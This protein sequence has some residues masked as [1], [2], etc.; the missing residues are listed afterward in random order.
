MN[1]N[2]DPRK[3]LKQYAALEEA[4]KSEIIQILSENPKGRY[5]YFDCR[6]DDENEAYCASQFPV[7]EGNEEVIKICGVGL[8]DDNHIVIITEDDEEKWF[9]PDEFT[10]A[11]LDMY[12]FVVDNLDYAKSSDCCDSE[13]PFDVNSVEFHDGLAAIE[14]EDGKWGYIDKTGQVVIPCQ[15]EETEYFSDGFA[16]V[17]DKDDKWGFIDKTGQVVIPCQWENVSEFEEGQAIVQ[18]SNEMF[19]IIDKNGKMVCPCKWNY[20][21]NIVEGLMLVEDANC[22]WGYIDKTGQV[23]IPCQ[24]EDAY[25]FSHGLAVVKDSKGKMLKID[26]TGKVVKEV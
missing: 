24:W 16:S 25:D 9:E 26:K 19:G 3:Y 15:W 1:N 5:I 7:M 22:K 14:N 13:L 17:K 6:F 4:A 10:H 12:E 23:V 20:M 21:S 8:N 18:N 11:Y 2:L